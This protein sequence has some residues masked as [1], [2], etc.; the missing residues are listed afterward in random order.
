M[1]VSD[2]SVRPLNWLP[3]PAASGPSTI[4]EGGGDLLQMLLQDR[5]PEHPSSVGDQSGVGRDD[6]AFVEDRSAMPREEHAG[7]AESVLVGRHDGEE[8]SGHDEAL[9]TALAEEARRQVGCA[10]NLPVAD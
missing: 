5:L 2:H 6:A 4:S 8:T 9:K 7:H 3:L 10:G 1:Q